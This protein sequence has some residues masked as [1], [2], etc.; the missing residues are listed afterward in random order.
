M[1]TL[2]R[3]PKSP[4]S[5]RS[6][7][8]QNFA[9]PAANVSQTN[10]PT[11][12]SN[13]TALLTKVGCLLVSIPGPSS[14]YSVLFTLLQN[15]HCLAYFLTDFGFVCI[16]TATQKSYLGQCRKELFTRMFKI[17]YPDGK[18]PNTLWF[19]FYRRKFLNM[20]LPVSGAAT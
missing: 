1:G 14:L 19:G 18:T 16:E 10:L 13:Q 7:F 17:L 2:P 8:W 5:K 9:S 12:S 15:R 4:K 20:T 11:S 6:F 3:V